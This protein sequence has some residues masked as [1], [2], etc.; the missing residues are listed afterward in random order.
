M[1]DEFEKETEEEESFAE[2]LEA[3]GVERDQDVRIGDKI[4]GKII[5][6]ERDSVF[7]DTGSKIDGAVDKQ[8]LLDEDGNLPYEI[9]DTLELY[10]VT[11]T[12]NEIQLSKA[13]SGIGSLNE[14][15]DA[16]EAK[17]PVEG[18]VAAECKGGF[19]VTVLQKRAFCPISH[20]D[21][22]YIEN[23][24][25]YVGQ[26]HPFLITRF[27]ENGR[28]IVVSRKMLLQQELTASRKEFLKTLTVGS[29]WKG[30]VIRLMPYGAFVE[31]EKGV[32]G[33]VH[34][35]Q[36]SWSRVSDPKDVVSEGEMLDVKVTEIR[37]TDKPDQPRI[38][39]SAKQV[40]DDPWESVESTFK[41]GDVVEGRVTRCA[42]FGAFME[43]APGI[44]GLVHISEMSYTKR[45]IHPE[46]LVKSDERVPVMIKEINAGGKRMSLSMRDAEGDPWIGLEDKFPAGSAVT[47]QIERKE[48][49]GYFVSL[50]PGVTGLL[51]ISK[52]NSATNRSEIE[53]CKTGDKIAV[54]VESLHV[55]DRK[56]SL[57]PGSSQEEGDWKHY[58]QSNE[59]TLG[60][61]GEKLQQALHRQK[62]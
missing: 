3:Y 4:E 44:E 38:A 7:L 36:L 22:N 53:K 61:L 32:E 37:E 6:I 27:E 41:I 10:V 14:L 45:V 47:G 43:I 42:Q 39:L 51:P 25:I 35:S 56:I 30:R 24:E 1:S 58:S 60:S 33:M 28:N 16:Y 18:K 46:D 62:K 52:I 17:V 8:E 12:E 31:L 21:I 29:T 49:F 40:L 55:S 15:Q 5:A 11:A 50:S 34:V 9:G 2:L 20:M 48:K 57:A 54:I 23:G 59:N 26:V 13:L 19:H